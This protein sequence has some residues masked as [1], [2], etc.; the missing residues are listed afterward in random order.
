M[1]EVPRGRPPLAHRRDDAEIEVSRCGHPWGRTRPVEGQVLDVDGEEPG[2]ALMNLMALAP[3][4][5]AG[6]GRLAGMLS[7]RP[8]SLPAEAVG[9]AGNP[10]DAAP[11]MTA[12]LP[13]TRSKVTS[14]LVPS[15]RRKV[16]QEERTGVDASTLAW[17]KSWNW[18]DT[19]SSGLANFKSS[20]VLLRSLTTWAQHGRT[21]PAR[22]TKNSTAQNRFP[23]FSPLMLVP[24]VSR[25]NAH[26]TTLPV[27]RS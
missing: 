23:H 5:S 27:P 4:R 10:G 3:P 24:P 18:G 26:A 14:H 13:V 9:R 6:P 17:L 15:S 21:I 16:S 19:L 11:S 7:R 20:S 8:R 2:W 25:P 12:G 22:K 1:P